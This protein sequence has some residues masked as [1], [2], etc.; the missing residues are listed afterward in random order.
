LRKTNKILLVHTGGI[1]DLIMARP[2]IQV[3]YR[4]YQSSSI[5]FMGN[6]GSLKI[7]MQDN[8][9]H[10]FIPVPSK[11]KNILSIMQI[12]IT[13]L[14]IRLEKYDYLFLLQPVLSKDSNWRLKFFVN[15]ISAKKTIGRKSNFGRNF[16]DVA[17]PENASLHEVDRMLSVVSEVGEVY[18]SFEYYLPDTFTGKLNHPGN[19]PDKPFAILSPGGA[20]KFR[21][22]PVVNF[23]ELAQRFHNMGMAVVF[24]GDDKEKDILSGIGEHLPEG[25][26]NMIGETDLEQLIDIIRKSSIVVA[27]DSGPMHL[28]NALKIPVVGIFGSGDSVRTRPYIMD[29]TR[30]IDSSA[31][32]C[33]PCY[34]QECK[35]PHCMDEISVDSVWKAAA[36]L[37]NGQY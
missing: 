31:R 12:F 25:T 22:W 32:D 2:A 6:P 9:I 20:K 3:A 30:V 1:G 24:I 19:I 34:R 36:D 21:R 17:V 13:L 7:L 8:W 10:K 11:Q 14:K 35:S 37:L 4:K 15:I 28:A 5:D 27:N 23:L 26:L 16:F 18:G 33:K 29:M